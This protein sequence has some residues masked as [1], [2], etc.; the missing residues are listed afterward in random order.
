MLLPKWPSYDQEQISAVVDVLSSGKVNTWTGQETNLFEEEFAAFT[1]AQC[2][3]AMS[4]GSLALSAAYLAIGLG[5]GD[6]IITSPRTFI[7]TASSAILLGAKPVF[8][9]VDE[10]SG[11]ITAETIEPHLTAKTKAICVVHLGG[12]PA[13][14]DKI[15]ELANSFNIPL[16]EDCAQAHGAKFNGKSVGSFGSISA[17]SFCQDK[18]MTTGGEGG[19]V[20][21]NNL[22]LFDKVWSIK[23]HGK[24][25]QLTKNSVKKTGFQ[26][27]HTS[28][29]S[30][31]RLTELQ[32]AIGRIQLKRLPLWTKLRERNAMIL[33]DV[34]SECKLLRVPVPPKTVTHAWY[35]F[36]AFIRPET[37]AEGW[38]RDMIIDKVLGLGYPLFSGSCSEIYLEQCFIKAGL[39]PTD[40]LPVARSLGET[41]LMLLVHPNIS[42]EQMY[43]YASALIYVLNQARR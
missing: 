28:F 23:D 30:N 40:R 16:I 15:L 18:I 9:D 29:G 3:V 1:G 43:S 41:S 8:A 27:V 12:W 42:S 33:Y 32:S 22:D 39:S 17:W 20:T 19:M 24:S 25:Y 2:A 38:S 34:L 11:A 10:D 37:I 4:N 14:I 36:Y 6:E 7:A 26:W 5:R 13:E 21:T 31:F 35:K